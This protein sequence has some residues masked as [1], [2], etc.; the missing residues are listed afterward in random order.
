MDPLN[1]RQALALPVLAALG[2]TLRAMPLARFPLGV[3]TDEIDEDLLNAAR[4]LNEF[5]LQWAEIR[6]VWGK[7]N[8][9][10]SVD[11]IQEARALL[12]RH[13]IRTSVLGTAFFKVPL[14]PGDAA[15]DAQWKLLDAAMERAAILGA[16]RLRIFA[17]TYEGKGP[18]ASAYPRI[19]ELLSE[20]ARRARP[21]KMKLAIENV[22]QSYVWSAAESARVLKELKDDSVGL[23]WDPN[24]AAQSGER[25]FPDGYHLLDPARIIH[26]HLRDY[27]HVDGKVEWCAVGDGEFDNAGQ[28]RALLKDGYRGRFTLET[29]Y[30]SPQGKAHASRTSLTGL[31]KVVEKL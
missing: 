26:V 20:A 23:A 24:N 15:L 21:R 27:K 16:A 25:P 10:Q 4:F 30:R 18:D 9:A 11:K 13:K 14:P 28:I 5:G 22:A 19:V 31:L 6:S 12:D 3:T 2:R 1:R 8:T 7:Y 17:F 29:H